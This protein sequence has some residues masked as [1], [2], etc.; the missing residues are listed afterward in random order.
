MVQEISSLYVSSSYA[1]LMSWL[2][3]R[4]FCITVGAKRNKSVTNSTLNNNKSTL[5]KVLYTLNPVIFL[6]CFTKNE[7]K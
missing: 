6:S 5:M 1:G 7:G 2:I 3:D 4:A